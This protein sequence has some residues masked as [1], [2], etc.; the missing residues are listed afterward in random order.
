MITLDPT[1]LPPTVPE[2]VQLTM[3]VTLSDYGITHD[4]NFYVMIS[5]CV[6]SSF[7]V[8]ADPNRDYVYDLGSQAIE[9]AY[10]E[11]AFSPEYCLYEVQKKVYLLGTNT[12][13]TFITLDTD[14]FRV[15]T[16]NPSKIGNYII[17]LKMT[18]IGPNT[19]GP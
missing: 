18:P 13:P 8:T 2:F 4:E 17:E 9:V 7:T 10:P 14:H 16:T 6:I 15:F 5:D 11:V 1:K 3:R 12:I 19:V